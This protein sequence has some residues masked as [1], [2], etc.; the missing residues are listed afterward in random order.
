MQVTRG[1]S[2]RNETGALSDYSFASFCYIW[3]DSDGSTI[4]M[5]D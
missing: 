3:S 1:I 4:M 5:K 2:N